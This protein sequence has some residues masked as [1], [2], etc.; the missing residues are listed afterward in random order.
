M[1]IKFVK[2]YI[3]IANTL[4]AFVYASCLTSGKMPI[5][6]KMPIMLQITPMLVFLAIVMWCEVQEGNGEE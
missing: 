2:S 6:E 4:V 3:K 5:M 1:K